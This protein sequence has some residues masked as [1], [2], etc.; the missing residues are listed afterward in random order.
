M[1]LAPLN[2]DCLIGTRLDLLCVGRASISVVFLMGSEG[3]WISGVSGVAG[4]SGGRPG[5]SPGGF[6][7]STGEVF[8]LAGDSLG[9]IFEGKHP[10][11]AP[12]RRQKQFSA[13]KTGTHATWRA[14]RSLG[15]SP[16][17]PAAVWRPKVR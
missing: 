17:C 14:A 2:L 10:P 12:K 9:S 6:G 5:V 15:G 1:M 4:A 8:G 7:S 3:L 16:E 13:L 11:G